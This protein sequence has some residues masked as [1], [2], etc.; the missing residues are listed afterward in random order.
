MKNKP[1]LEVLLVFLLFNV[2]KPVGGFLANSGILQKELA[3]F[4]WSFLGG[5]FLIIVPVLI[6]L[7]FRRNFADFGLTLA[8]WPL[9][10]D[11]GL[12]GYL[13]SLIPWLIGFG[14]LM[15]FFQTGYEQFAG[16]VILSVCYLLV[17]MLLLVILRKR[18]ADGTDA[19]VDQKT[20]SNLISI[21]VLLS[22]PVI[23]GVFTQ[24]FS[25]KL[26]STVIWQLVISGF[27]EEIY[28]RGYIQSRLNHG[29]GKNLRVLGFEFGWGLIVA[30][31]LF[32]LS[33]V[34]NPFN[35]L[36][37]QVQISWWWGLWTFFSGLFFGILRER[38]G[39]ILASSITHGVVDAVGE[40][41]NVIF[42]FF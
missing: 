38:T 10:L 18:N 36:A 30:S 21:A 15:S 11:L 19:K 25:L 9:G 6:L 31:L 22:L 17:I 7:V 41:L 3:L 14:L 26:V 24:R 37:G 39:S 16:A 28:W 1:I 34:L 33:H 8:N 35:L 4:G 29:F 23:L 20:K 13:L 42:R 27:G 12:V 40:G 32:G 5:S 2:L